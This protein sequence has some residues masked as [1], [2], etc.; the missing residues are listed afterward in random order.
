MLLIEQLEITDFV[1]SEEG[2]L[3]MILRIWRNKYLQ[4][5]FRR[6]LSVKLL[7]VIIIPLIQLRLSF[8]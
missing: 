5:K 3:G 4:E 7:Y 6:K 1:A 2:H 8:H